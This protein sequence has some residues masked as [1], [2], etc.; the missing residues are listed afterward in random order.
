MTQSLESVS[1]APLLT[2]CPEVSAL[3][4]PGYP[5]EASGPDTALHSTGKQIIPQ[6]KC[7]ARLAYSEARRGEGRAEKKR[8]G[9][10][11]EHL[12]HL[13]A[14]SEGLSHWSSPWLPIRHSGSF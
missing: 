10:E 5:P 2:C 4:F 12:L 9:R 7:S 1:F 6:H 13:G 11:A 8:K 3:L 14:I